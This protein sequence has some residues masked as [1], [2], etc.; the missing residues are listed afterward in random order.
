[1]NTSLVE[2]VFITTNLK[3]RLNKAH[4]NE[5]CKSLY[6]KNLDSTKKDIQLLP[7]ILFEPSETKHRL[8]QSGTKETCIKNVLLLSTYINIC[9][10]ARI[11]RTRSSQS[12]IAL[13]VQLQTY[14]IWEIYKHQSI[15]LQS[16]H[17]F[18]KKS[19]D[20]TDKLSL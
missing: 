1:M 10:L 14:I 18:S 4:C 6:T 16:F 9:L 5:V 2:T 7:N 8:F 3:G 15:I 19:P 13:K 11:N 20:I 17:N 12:R